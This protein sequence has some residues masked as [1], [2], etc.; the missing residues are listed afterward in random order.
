MRRQPS[1]ASRRNRRGVAATE[2]AV[3]LP[4]LVLLLL[5]MIETCSMVFLKQSLA[6]AAYEGAH[7]ALMPDATAAD[8]R[9]VC[10][11]ILADRRVQ[12]ATIDVSPSNLNS[13]PDGDYLEVTITAPS[14]RNGVIPGRFFRGQTLSSTAVMMKEI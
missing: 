9:R 11:E 1:T 6:C 5:G 4:V 13:M 7:T 10:E 2:F 12:G 14:D 3:C 8:V